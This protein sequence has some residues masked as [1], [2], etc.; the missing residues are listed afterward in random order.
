MTIRKILGISMIA[1]GFMIVMASL[2][3]YR[4]ANWDTVDVTIIGLLGLAFMLSGV[5]L[6]AKDIRPT[7]E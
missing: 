4:L 1:L 5:A 7:V 6:P 3:L 2:G